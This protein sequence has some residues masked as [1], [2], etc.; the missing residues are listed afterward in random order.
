M[1]LFHKNINKR[2]V[3]HILALE[4]IGLLTDDWYRDSQKVYE[5]ERVDKKLIEDLLEYYKTKKQ[6]REKFEKILQRLAQLHRILKLFLKK[7]D[8]SSRDKRFISIINQFVLEIEKLLEGF[9]FRIGVSGYIF[10]QFDTEKVKLGIAKIF[11]LLAR[12]YIKR[13]IEVISKLVDKGVPALA[14]REAAKRNWKKI[15]IAPANAKKYSC[16]PVDEEIIEGTDWMDESQR[17]IDS[18]DLFIKIGDDPIALYE[19]DQIKS[20]EKDIE[21]V[22]LN[23]THLDAKISDVPRI[24]QTAGIP[25]ATREKI[26]LIVDK[27]LVKACLILYDKNIRT[28]GTSANINDIGS[29]AWITIDYDNLSEENKR[30]AEQYCQVEQGKEIKVA[31][32]KIPIQNGEVLISEIEDKSSN[33]ARKFKKQKMTWANTMTYEQFKKIY[34][35]EREKTP[36]EVAK[37]GGWIWDPKD[38]LFYVSGKEHYDKVVKSRNMR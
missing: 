33:I 1:N 31:E 21:I 36:Q 13:K 2:L 32:I 12:K 30:I 7:S 15:G 35:P 10:F 16:Y 24:F 22:E 17:F 28:T 26:K 4:E 18:I 25:I 23:A 5:L 37:E 3:Q 27:P 9:P 29:Y 6:D 38:K 11:N 19:L 14:Y 34:H 8:A 20:W